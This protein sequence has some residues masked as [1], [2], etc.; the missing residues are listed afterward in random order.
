MNLLHGRNF[1]R[2]RKSCGQFVLLSVHQN[3]FMALQGD[4]VP[5]TEAREFC[6]WVSSD[7]PTK[8]SGTQFSV[9]ALGDRWGPE[10]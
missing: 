4:G 1:H 10:L 6:D 8:L 7:A 9:C 3:L 5:P 2:C